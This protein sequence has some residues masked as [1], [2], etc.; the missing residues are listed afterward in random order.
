MPY[1]A[2]E[3]E[4]LSDFLLKSDKCSPLTTIWK[5]IHTS[6]QQATWFEALFTSVAQTLQ[7]F[8]TRAPA[9]VK[10]TYCS[11]LA[12]GSP[13][14]LLGS[15][16]SSW[17]SPPL[18]MSRVGDASSGASFSWFFTSDP[19]TAPLVP[20]LGITIGTDG[21]GLTAPLAFLFLILCLRETERCGENVREWE[22]RGGYE[23][24]AD[25]S[26]VM[27]VLC[28]ACCRVGGIVWVSL[29]KNEERETWE[30][31]EVLF[32]LADMVIMI[33]CMCVKGSVCSHFSSS[34]C[35][36][37]KVQLAPLGHPPRCCKSLHILVL[38]LLLG[39]AWERRAEYISDSFKMTPK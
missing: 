28:K 36:W 4:S 15:V 1:F 35:V 32:W 30:G 12:A 26:T 23:V 18:G 29:N 9:I 3:M 38:Y 24:M 27:P 14:A 10:H 16:L 2:I 21:K 13:F 22:R 39:W 33:V 34:S 31:G 20:L 37:A 7:E 8:H 17:W 6:P 19:G 5:A 25:P 11:R